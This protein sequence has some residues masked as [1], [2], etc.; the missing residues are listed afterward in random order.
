MCIYILNCTLS[1]SS[2]FFLQDLLIHLCLHINLSDSASDLPQDF[3]Q[4]L[5][6]NAA[7]SSCMF[8]CL[9]MLPCLRC[10]IFPESA[11]FVV[12]MPCR[13]AEG[14]TFYGLDSLYLPVQ[15]SIGTILEPLIT[16]QQTGVSKLG[17]LKSKVVSSLSPDL[18]RWHF[19]GIHWYTLVYQHTTKSIQIMVWETSPET[20]W[21]CQVHRLHMRLDCVFWCVLDSECLARSHHLAHRQKRSASNV[22]ITLISGLRRW[23]NWGEWTLTKN[24]HAESESAQCKSLAVSRLA[25]FN[26][27]FTPTPSPR[28]KPLLWY[29]YSAAYKPWLKQSYIKQSVFFKP[30]FARTTC[31]I[32]QSLNDFDKSWLLS[33]ARASPHCDCICRKAFA[34]HLL[35][36]FRAVELH[37]KTD[38]IGSVPG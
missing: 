2:D 14:C 6:S 38:G 13:I 21:L 27:I 26:F 25:W 19:Y 9:V 7:S 33:L 24:R 1:A 36:P 10:S 17:T 29:V 30:D 5:H 18:H 12:W 16:M 11:I 20:H 3:R 32:L 22:H 28:H 34:L 23:D 4:I 31:E 37:P 8:L 15:F 35:C